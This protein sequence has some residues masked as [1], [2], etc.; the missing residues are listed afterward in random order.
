M[1]QMCQVLRIDGE[2]VARSMTAAEISLFRLFHD[3][4]L[5]CYNCQDSDGSN[6]V[7]LRVDKAVNVMFHCFYLKNDVMG[8]QCTYILHRDC[9][10]FGDISPPSRMPSMG[11]ASPCRSIQESAVPI[12]PPAFGCVAKLN[13]NPRDITGTF[14]D[15][16][17]SMGFGLVDAT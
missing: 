7:V 5:V 9:G 15:I 13:Y 1:F 4:N 12:S 11:P 17:A 6:F 8:W 14:H 10:N 16:V 3:P 2:I